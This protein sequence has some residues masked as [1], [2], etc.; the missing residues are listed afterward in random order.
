MP[1]SGFSHSAPHTFPC[2]YFYNEVSPNEWLWTLLYVSFVLAPCSYSTLLLDLE[3]HPFSCSV[4]ALGNHKVAV[5]ELVIICCIVCQWTRD[6]TTYIHA[7]VYVGSMEGCCVC[8]TICSTDVAVIFSALNT[9]TVTR[10]HA[11]IKY[12]AEERGKGTGDKAKN[13]TMENDTIDT[14]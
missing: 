14:G 1:D 3:L 10:Q 6:M 13:C 12:T 2:S 4:A 8:D 11:K 9:I 5:R 7:I